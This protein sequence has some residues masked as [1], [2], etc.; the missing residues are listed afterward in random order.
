[1]DINSLLPNEGKQLEISNNYGKYLRYPIKTHIVM[2]GDSLTDIM[3]K[4]VKPYLQKDDMI[5]ISEK[6]VAISQG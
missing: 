4:Y 6:I 3:D 1:M 2:S 5:F